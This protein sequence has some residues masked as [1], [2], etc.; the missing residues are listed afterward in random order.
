MH[1]IIKKQFALIFFTLFPAKAEDIHVCR[2]IFILV[3]Y[4]PPLA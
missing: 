4:I 3:M 1:E 2:N